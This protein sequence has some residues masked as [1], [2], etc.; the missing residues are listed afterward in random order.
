M[1]KYFWVGWLICCASGIWAQNN[2]LELRDIDFEDILVG[3]FELRSDKQVSIDAT[4]AGQE[5]QRKYFHSRFYDPNDMF[6]YSWIINAD[7]RELVWRITRGNSREI[8]SEFMRNFNGSLKLASG[9]YEVYMCAREPDK[10]MINND[11]FPS[12][13]KWLKHFFNTDEFSKDILGKCHITVSGVDRTFDRRDVLTYQETIRRNAVVSISNIRDSEVYD[14]RFSLT[15]NGTFEIYA[16]GE[17]LED[18]L[19]DYGWIIREDNGETVWEMDDDH[20]EYAGGATKNR[21]W[22]TTISLPSGNYSVHYV[23]D[24]THSSEEW[25]A[26]PPYDPYFWGVTLRGVSGKFDPSAITEFRP[27]QTRPFVEMTR[28][29]DDEYVERTFELSK[30]AKIRIHAMGEGSDGDMSDYGWITDARTG[31][32][33][34]EMTFRESRHAGGGYKNRV[35]DTVIDFPAGTYRVYFVTDGSHSFG[36]WNTRPPRN[37]ADWGITLEMSEPNAAPQIKLLQEITPDPVIALTRVGDDALESVIFQVD[38]PTN[39]RVIAVGEG[40]N[41]EMFDFGW[42]EDM[43]TKRRIWQMD[44]RKTTHAGGADK[45]RQAEEVINFEPGTYTLYYRTDDSHAYRDWNSRAP[46]RPERWG[47]A[48]FPV[49]DDKPKG[50]HVLPGIP[51]APEIRDLPNE[52]VIAQI[53]EVHDDEHIRK[54]FRLNRETLMMVYA[55]GEGDDEMYD[56]GWIENRN[57]RETVWRMEYQKTEQAGGA[58]KNRLCRETIL[59]PAGEYV[60]HY[61]TDG[62]HSFEEWN[63]R[64]PRD[65]FN[66]GITLYE[67]ERH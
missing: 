35:V 67:L 31:K 15:E 54:T 27:K 45:N 7:T 1:K 37:G 38:K 12:L 34:W 64:P 32:K 8:D 61:L 39:L 36:H 30:S 16:L 26:N 29:G 42:I 22:R 53:I 49:D 4:G 59:L 23:T 3:G 48:L 19:Y 25:N 13:G 62:S 47:I 40:R 60:L 24:D 9:R 33:I 41:D 56:Y 14:R 46:Y 10:I 63:A 17:S 51:R 11:N 57:T 5:G 18:G 28:L 21:Q 66:Y 6:V 55:I 20:S 2:R 58:D 50:L 43:R 44:Y 52:N 65:R